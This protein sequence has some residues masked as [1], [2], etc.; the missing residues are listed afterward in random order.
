MT[1]GDLYDAIA[2]TWW[3]SLTEAERCDIVRRAAASGEK[4]IVRAAREMTE[5]MQR[6]KVPEART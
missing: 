1:P 4:R 2:Y 6:Q 5:H 3:A